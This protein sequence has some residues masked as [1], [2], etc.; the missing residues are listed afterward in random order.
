MEHKTRART[1]AYCVRCMFQIRRG[2]LVNVSSE[3]VGY[4]HINCRWAIEDGTG[5]KIHPDFKHFLNNMDP[6][7]V[8]RILGKRKK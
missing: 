1:D 2:E 6:V 4:R 7:E 5:R 8:E 3:P